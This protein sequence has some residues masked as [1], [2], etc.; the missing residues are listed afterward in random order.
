M[1]S[2]LILQLLNKLQI[3]IN[4]PHL[5]DGYKAKAGNRINQYYTWGKITNDYID[6]FKVLASK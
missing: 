6:L 1:L 2:K 4:S 5:R 3:I